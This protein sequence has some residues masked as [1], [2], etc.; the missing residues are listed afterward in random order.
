LSE[1]EK[2]KREGPLKIK[3]CGFLF[4]EGKDQAF[5]RWDEHEE[6]VVLVKRKRAVKVPSKGKRKK[7]N[8]RRRTTSRKEEKK[9]K[10]KNPL[11]A[12][13]RGKTQKT[14]L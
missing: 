4:A 1:G 9:K 8:K 5:S 10:K 13:T 14:I 11:L 2:K 6:P 3:G 7:N 12:V